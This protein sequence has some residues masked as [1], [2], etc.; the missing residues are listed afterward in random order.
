MQKEVAMSQHH[1]IAMREGR[2]GRH[3]PDHAMKAYR[4]RRGTAPI[5]LNLSTSGG[6]WSTSHW[7]CFTSRKEPWHP[8]SSRMGGPHTQSGIF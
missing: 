2:G 6:Q 4:G 3:V 7:D 8:L 1:V 5:I